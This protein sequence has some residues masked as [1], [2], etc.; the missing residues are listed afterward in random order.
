VLGKAPAAAT[1]TASVVNDSPA[2]PASVVA[3]ASTTPTAD[4]TPT[5]IPPLATPAT[6]PTPIA[7]SDGHTWYTSAAGNATRYYCDLDSGWKDLSPANLRSY[8]S[9]AALKAAWG[10]A[11]TKS[12]SSRC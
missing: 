12:P 4:S 3:G 6:P 8:P 1:P 10:S 9:E 2:A 7:E 5:P 11:R